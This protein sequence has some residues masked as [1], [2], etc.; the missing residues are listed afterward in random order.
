MENSEAM[1]NLDSK[2]IRGINIKVMLT[3]LIAVI[4]STITIVMTINKLETS[5]LK[6]QSI[7]EKQS[8]VTD[9]KLR[10][11]D[12]RITNLEGE[13]KEQNFQIQKNEEKLNDVRLSR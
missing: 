9:L 8:E 13:Q 5:I 10:T 12:I 11:L 2:E 4:S 1:T 7:Q 3:I 6:I